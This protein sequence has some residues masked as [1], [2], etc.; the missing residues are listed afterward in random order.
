LRFSECAAIAV[1]IHAVATKRSTTERTVMTTIALRYQPA[2][3][4]AAA[5]NVARLSDPFISK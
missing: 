5:P 2:C 3:V 4:S 1:S